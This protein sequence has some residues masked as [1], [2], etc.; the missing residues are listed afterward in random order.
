MRWKRRFERKQ[1]NYVK[2]REEKFQEKMMRRLKE[3]KQSDLWKQKEEQN[4]EKKDIVRMR[5]K[6]KNVSNTKRRMKMF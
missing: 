4:E 1:G 5:R 3:K 6:H 2:R